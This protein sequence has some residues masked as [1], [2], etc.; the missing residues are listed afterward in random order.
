[1]VVFS[2]ADEAE[3]WLLSI[4]GWF[5]TRGGDDGEGVVT[6]NKTVGREVISRAGYFQ[7]TLAGV[8]R[9]QAIEGARIE[10]CKLLRAH[11]SGEEE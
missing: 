3:K 2:S 9:K 8:A 7:S 10:A 5:E 4:E 11:L 6:A 1:M